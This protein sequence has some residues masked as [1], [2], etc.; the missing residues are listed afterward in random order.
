MPLLDF[1]K[2][3]PKEKKLAVPK[4]QTRKEIKKAVEKPKKGETRKTSEI[5]E[6]QKVKRKKATFSYSVLKSPHI[7]EKVTDLTKKN[8]YVFRVWPKTNKTAIKKTTEDLY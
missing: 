3:K 4:D 5:K 6:G 8:Q 1:F 7:T 2:K